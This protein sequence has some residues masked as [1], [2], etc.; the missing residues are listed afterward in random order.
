MRFEDINLFPNDEN[1][2]LKAYICDSMP[3][4][5]NRR[6][7][8]LVI[9]G[10]GYSGVCT[11]REGDAVARAFL[12]EGFNAFVLRYSVKPYATDFRPLIQAA[13]SI[14]YI[15]ENAEHFSTD[16]DRIF[17]VG[18]SAGGHLAG[19]AGVFWNHPILSETL[20]DVSNGICR[21]T[22]MILCY[23]VITSGSFA[24]RGSF[25]NLC[26]KDNAT[27]E[28]MA[29]Y[30]LENF[31]NSETPPAFIWHTFAD[32]CVPVE[33]S[34]LMASALR[35]NGVPFELHIYPEGDHGLSLATPET[36]GGGDGRVAR[37][38]RTWF[39]LSVKWTDTVKCDRHFDF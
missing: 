25:L 37:H 26:G 3:N 34:L 32:T 24:H 31:V 22:G 20:G 17:V 2:Y 13:T 9:P 38:L 33:N 5:N 8:V 39:D 14:K 15:R 19:S 11:D 30:S 12:A 23:P 4:F 36:L 27:D 7:A 16:P 18:F 35:E 28:E 21:P 10:G 6:K 29:I 1:T